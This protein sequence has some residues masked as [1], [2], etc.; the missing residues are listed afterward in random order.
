MIGKDTGPIEDAPSD[1]HP[2]FR[3]QVGG[4]GEGEHGLLVVKQPEM[5]N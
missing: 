3:G 1:V 2:E 4:E 5:E